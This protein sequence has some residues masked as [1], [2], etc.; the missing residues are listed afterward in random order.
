MKN[1]KRRGAPTPEMLIW[2]GVV[3]GFAA[4]TVQI[5]LSAFTDIPAI[6]SGLAL[7]A[8]FSAA[9]TVIILTYRSTLHQYNSM[10]EKI[11][12]HGEAMTGLVEKLDI[13]AVI[14][15]DDGTV[16]WANRALKELFG[17]AE[18]DMFGKNMNRFCPFDLHAIKE[19][20]R[21]DEDYDSLEI[22]R[23]IAY[24]EPV[25]FPP[26][27]AD[28]YATY[29]R[30]SNDHGG[31]EFVIRGR[32]FQA[33]S[34]N[35]DVPV[36]TGDRSRKYNLTIFD[37]STELFDLKD[38]TARKNLTVAYVV[39]DN[40]AELAEYVRVNYRV[41]ANN[42]EL[43]IKD[44]AEELGGVLC[45]Y[46]R[47]KYMIL[48]SQE[49]LEKTIVEGFPILE[50][51]RSEKLGD[52]SMSVTVSMGISSVGDTVAERE[53]N[54]KLALDTALRRGGDQI[55]VKKAESMDF[56]GGRSKGIQKREKVSSRV[57]AKRLREIIGE[58]SKIFVMGHRNP[59]CDSIGASVGMAR[60]AKAVCPNAS[61]HV[62]SDLGNDTFK[63]CTA[64][65]VGRSDG[66]MLFQSA[67]TALDEVSSDS[68]L[69]IVDANNFNI[70]ES[71]D[72]ANSISDIVVIDHHRKTADLERK[73]MLEYI[74]PSASSASELIAEML[75]SE[76]S[77]TTLLKEEADVMLSGIMLDTMNFT[78]TTGMRTF[79]AAYFLRAAGASSERARGFFRDDLEQHL[80]E[81]KFF[82]PENVVIYRNNI[83]IAVSMGSDEKYD[84]IAASKAAERLIS[85]RRVVAAFALVKIGS[86]IH[87]SARSTGT[88]NVQ[89]ILE[90]IGGGGH[91]DSAGALVTG[92]TMNEALVI[93]KDAINKYFEE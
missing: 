87:V 1:D 17:N 64:S 70:I 45:E 56:Y 36:E 24:D 80:A 4:L 21:S 88:V 54:A 79:S 57:I 12:H 26:E 28:I 66:G 6:Y 22:A 44:W 27:N 77:E 23:R 86:S 83:A 10:R 63:A 14:T 46:D 3:A 91:F 41:A 75:E 61:V 39:L 58:H 20:T 72:L 47:D 48:F 52:N 25:T 62:V 81:A 33:K 60:F 43:H 29:P 73:P 74:D 85:V 35:V 82:D 93:L 76:F 42:I 78:R 84:R 90:S 71:T 92:R 19:A 89:L 37:E 32:R 68:L 53:R 2:L 49:M 16:I 55:V 40:L 18:L 7:A 65:L 5:L 69:I 8:L 51:I 38:E 30:V 31:L 34:Y 67:G 59:D 11:V 50:K 13:P 9:A 15:H